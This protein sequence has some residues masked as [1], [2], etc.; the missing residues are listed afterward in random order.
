MQEDLTLI[1]VGRITEITHALIL[2][3]YGLKNSI[4]PK[5]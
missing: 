2:M 4:G 3:G 5:K 1:H